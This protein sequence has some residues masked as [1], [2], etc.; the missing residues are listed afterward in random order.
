VLP[1]LIFSV[2]SNGF[3]TQASLSTSC[4]PSIITII[5]TRHHHLP[6]VIVNNSSGTTNSNNSLA[7][8]DE[9]SI[10]N[11][12]WRTIRRGPQKL[13]QTRRRT[14]N[15]ESSFKLICFKIKTRSKSSSPRSETGVD[16]IS[17]TVG[18]FFQGGPSITHHGEQNGGDRNM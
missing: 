1:Y 12:Q 16:A 17:E 18:F 3:A 4:L 10:W 8:A 15:Q 11:T 13:E 9:R 7:R 5:I 14:I 6:A 2:G